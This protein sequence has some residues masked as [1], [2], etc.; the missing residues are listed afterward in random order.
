MAPLT[1]LQGIGGG[2]IPMDGFSYVVSRADLARMIDAMPTDAC[3]AM[4]LAT[5]RG[6][7]DTA[8][9]LLRE[10]AETYFTTAPAAPPAPLMPVHPRRK[11][12][13]NPHFR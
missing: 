1:S 6:D 10:A 2:R 13:K 5:R 9:R 3:Q 4:H 12:R 11:Q 8:Q 7:I